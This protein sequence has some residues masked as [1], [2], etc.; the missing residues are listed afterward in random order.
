MCGVFVGVFEILKKESKKERKIEEIEWF[1]VSQHRRRHQK[2]VKQR[3]ICSWND[4]KSYE[5]YHFNIV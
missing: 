2:K 4:F 3:E 5:N 1:V